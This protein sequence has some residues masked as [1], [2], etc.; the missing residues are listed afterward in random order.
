MP[1]VPSINKKSRQFTYHEI[2]KKKIP[3]IHNKKNPG[4]PQ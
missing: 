4:Y 1:R 3:A 2:N